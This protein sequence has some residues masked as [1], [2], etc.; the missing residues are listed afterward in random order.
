MQS[1]PPT[2]WVNFRALPHHQGLTSLLPSSSGTWWWTS[3]HRLWPP[4]SHC[5]WA[6]K[7]TCQP[8]SG[9]GPGFVGSAWSETL[10]PKRHHTSW[11]VKEEATGFLGPGPE[12]NL[13]TGLCEPTTEVA[14]TQHILP[15]PTSRYQ[16][17]SIPSSFSW[18]SP[19]YLLL[20]IQKHSHKTWYQKPRW[21]HN[22]FCNG[23]CTLV[24]TT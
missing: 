8:Y 12:G 20:L 7:G 10:K 23:K 17:F 3:L 16:I 5:G 22:P 4:C 19:S 21:T 24:K 15:P 13:Q 1:Q 14:S 2:M 9:L 11:L 6:R 18:S